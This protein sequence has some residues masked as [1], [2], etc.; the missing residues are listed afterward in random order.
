[1]YNQQAMS[2]RTTRLSIGD[3]QQQALA[4]LTRQTAYIEREVYRVQY[5]DI[6]YPTLVPVDTSAPEWATSIEYYSS[7]KFGEAEWFHHQAN[8]VPMADVTQE[9]FTQQ[10][11]MAGIGYSY[12]LEELGAAMMANRNLTA[13]KA[14]AAKRAYEEFVDNVALRGNTTKGWTGLINDATVTAAVATADG[15]GGSPAWDDK[16]ADQVLRDVNALLSI[17]YT[18]T[19]TVEMANTLLLPVGAFTSIST[20]RIPDTAMTI[21]QFL[22]QFNTYT[23]VT[24]QPLVIRQVRGLESAGAGG[25]GRMVAYRRDP[26][27]LK[28]HIPM[29]H[30][31]EPVWRR[32]PI[33]YDVP[34]IFRLGPLEIRRPQAVR[35]VDGITDASYE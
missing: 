2:F 31:F 15:D 3:A 27:V 12:T 24:N 33:R 34:G 32:G 10:I 17:V 1:M 30:R 35:Y 4:F 28:I 16:T 26:Q 5:P 13:D 21:M 8:D 25:T 29:P 7:D 22:M 9:R 23:A 19:N 11:Y 20:R 6:Q 14:A 18:G